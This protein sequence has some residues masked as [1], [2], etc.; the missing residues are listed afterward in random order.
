MQDLAALCIIL[1][2]L[3]LNEALA[4]NNCVVKW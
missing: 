3:P 2:E 4:V 1:I